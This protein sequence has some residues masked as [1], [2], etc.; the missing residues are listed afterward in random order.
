MNSIKVTIIL[1]LLT[2][3]MITMGA[4]SVDAVKAA[5]LDDEKVARLAVEVSRQTEPSGYMAV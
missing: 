4:L 1:R 5:T 2:A 3:F